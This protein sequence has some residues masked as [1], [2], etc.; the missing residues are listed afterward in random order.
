[1][2]IKRTELNTGPRPYSV[3]LIGEHKRSKNKI[4]L[5]VQ[6]KRPISS[7]VDN[8][9]QEIHDRGF[10]YQRF[11]TLLGHLKDFDRDTGYHKIF[12]KAGAVRAAIFAGADPHSNFYPA[13][14]KMYRSGRNPLVFEGYVGAPE[15]SDESGNLKKK[16][17]EWVK[18]VL[19]K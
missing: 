17:V 16:M 13:E 4:T 15:Y 1:M 11:E 8:V 7:E 5:D 9:M 12:I 14:L 3:R 18:K 19:S 10:T 6:S 2:S